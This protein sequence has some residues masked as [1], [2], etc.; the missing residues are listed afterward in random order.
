MIH[1]RQRLRVLR[2]DLGFRENHPTIKQKYVRR[3]PAA[4]EANSGTEVL[5]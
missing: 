4:P 5:G 3:A 2:N 1:L